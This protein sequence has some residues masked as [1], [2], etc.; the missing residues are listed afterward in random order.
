[1]WGLRGHRALLA[2]SSSTSNSHASTLTAIS[3]S[4]PGSHGVK[5]PREWP[6][7]VALESDHGSSKARH[8]SSSMINPNSHNHHHLCGSASC[9]VSPC[10]SAMLLDGNSGPASPCS[11]ASSCSSSSCSSSFSSCKEESSGQLMRQWAPSP[12]MW[13][14]SWEMHGT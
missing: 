3:L 5:H 9:S 14:A 2:Q 7:A 8:S 12:A 11:S 6:P 13:A 1:M 4:D 10:S